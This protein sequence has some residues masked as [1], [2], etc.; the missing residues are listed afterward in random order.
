MKSV[1]RSTSPP[2][3]LAN[4]W[5]YIKEVESLSNGQR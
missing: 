5:D 1:I 4:I 2:F 3:Y